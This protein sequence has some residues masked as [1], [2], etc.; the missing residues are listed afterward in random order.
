MERDGI[1]LN[2]Q[3]LQDFTDDIET[4]LS[5]VLT[6]FYDKNNMSQDHAGRIILKEVLK[7][8]A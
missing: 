1:D 2:V 6:G 8:F 5:D 4:E 3:N 7:I